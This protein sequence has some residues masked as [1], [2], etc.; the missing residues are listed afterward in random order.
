MLFGDGYGGLHLYNGISLQVS[1]LSSFIHYENLYSA[2]SRCVSIKGATERKSD[3]LK[4]R[5]NRKQ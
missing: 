3:I 4:E 2:S 1:P 5:Q